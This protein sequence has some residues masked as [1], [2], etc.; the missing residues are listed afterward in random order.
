MNLEQ[1]KHMEKQEL[2]S[3]CKKQNPYTLEETTYK[4]WLP[5]C[6]PA[7]ELARNKLREK[8]EASKTMTRWIQRKIRAV[9]ETITWKIERNCKDKSRKDVG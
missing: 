7:W 3:A 9:K 6:Y 1:I 4:N 5:D 2:K 8:T